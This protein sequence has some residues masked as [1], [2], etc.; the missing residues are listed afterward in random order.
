VPLVADG[1]EDH[2]ALRDPGVVI[3]DGDREVGDLVGEVVRAV[4]RVDDPQMLGR[5][6][7][8]FVGF[9]A[10][11]RVRRECPLDH[12]GDGVL[13]L[14]VGVGDEVGDVLAPHGDPLAEVSGGDRAP[15]SGRL[16]G[17]GLLGRQHP[18]MTPS[19]LDGTAERNEI[20]R[21]RHYTEGC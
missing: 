10:E 5:G 4:D 20:G 1:V 15:G 7:P 21:P 13:G 19:S 14:D 6:V 18:G 9:L 12:G 8:L 11:D 17:D 16:L 2:A 3:G